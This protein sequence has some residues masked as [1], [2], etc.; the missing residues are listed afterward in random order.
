MHFHSGLFQTILRFADLRGGGALWSFGLFT[1]G[2]RRG[3]RVARCLE[4]GDSWYMGGQEVVLI[5]CVDLVF[6][7]GKLLQI[8]LFSVCSSNALRN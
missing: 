3:R 4:E 5:L 6:D 8:N 1:G 7:E 2:K